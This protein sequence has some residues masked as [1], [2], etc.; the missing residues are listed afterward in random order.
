MK[1]ILL[2][3]GCALRCACRRACPGRDAWH[4]HGSPPRRRR[5][6]HQPR[7]SGRSCRPYPPAAEPAPAQADPHAGHDAGSQAGSAPSDM[8][9]PRRECAGMAPDGTQIGTAP[10]PAAPADHAADALFD[11]AAMALSRRSLRRENGAFSGSM[12]LFDLRISGTPGR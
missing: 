6:R 1:A 3:A 9:R 2:S 7:T 10:A 5:N 4:G 8:N 12:I 11:P